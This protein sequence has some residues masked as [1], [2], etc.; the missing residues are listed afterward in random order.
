MS[1]K[2]L[3]QTQANVDEA[4]DI[5]KGNMIRIIDR[6]EN[7]EKLEEGA[8]RLEYGAAELSKTARALERKKWWKNFKIWIVFGVVM[9]AVVTIIVVLI[10]FA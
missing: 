9:V 10:I 2:A 7:L 5:M 4:V 6:G 8:K 3:Q 1:S